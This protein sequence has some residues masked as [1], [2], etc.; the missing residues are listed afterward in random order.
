MVEVG[1]LSASKLTTFFGC[2]MAYYLKYVK[3][4][5]IPQNIR[6]LF[7]KSI[8]YM[9]DR[10]YEVSYKSAESFSNFWKYYWSGI[11]SGKFL[12]GKD[13]ERLKILEYPFMGRNK[14]GKK[15][16]K[17]LVVG[18][19][20]K[21]NP[22][23]KNKKGVYEED[24]VG[25]FF[26]YMRIGEDILKRFYKRHINKEPPIEREKRYYINLF[27]HPFVAILDRVDK[28]NG[29]YYLTDYK[30]DK[31]CPLKDSFI[32]HRHP[33]FT[34]Y[35]AVFREVF[36]DL[37][38]KVVEK[39]ILY[40]HLRTGNVL[41]TKR[42]QIDYDYVKALMDTAQ[43]RIE[44]NEFVPFYGF[45]CKD[46]DWKVPCEKYSVFYDGPRIDLENRILE[47]DPF[48]L[49]HNPEERKIWL[50]MAEER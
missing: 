21:F 28:I 49:W 48:L 41:K 25:E 2:P 33:Q 12:E 20:V 47:A 50:E 34:V 24:P 16:E 39:N 35:S 46:C 42:N 36:K 5:W 30:T 8:H 9:L 38:G 10:F 18:N 29:E 45:H 4:E 3:H 13:K 22:I 23:K 1:R 44:N 31:F 15:T 40:Y 19:H 6:L 17:V 11:I 32:L 37:F 26:N 27:G 7:G 43:R 14:S